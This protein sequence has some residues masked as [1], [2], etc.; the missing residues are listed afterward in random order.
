EELTSLHQAAQKELEAIRAE[1]ADAVK[2]G[3]NAGKRAAEEVASLRVELEKSA[4]VKLLAEGKAAEQDEISRKGEARLTE[5][6]KDLERLG[7]EKEAAEHRV[8]ELTAER[9]G[10]LTEKERLAAEMESLKARLETDEN[11]DSFA[12]DLVEAKAELAKLAVEK[13]AAERKEKK[14]A[15]ERDK[16][17]A[18]VERVT[19]RLGELQELQKRRDLE[20]EQAG[21]AQDASLEALRSELAQLASAR[22]EAEKRERELSALHQVT[23][24]ELAAAKAA[25][26]KGA[27]PAGGG[28][29]ASLAAL[30][31]ELVQLASAK[32]E[33]EKRELELS[34]RH[35]ITVAELA[36]VKAAL[37]KAIADKIAAERGAVDAGVALQREV[38]PE[39]RPEELS[40]AAAIGFALTAVRTPQAPWEVEG[41][42][43]AG[44]ESFS[45]A[46][47]EHPFGLGEGEDSGH[48]SSFFDDGLP[49]V[50]FTVD[51]ALSAVEY[52]APED[53]VALQLSINVARITPDGEL[54]QGSNAYVC[55][56]RKENAIHVFVAMYLIESRRTI[57]YVP[58][59]QPEDEGAYTKA[60]R[61]ALGFAEAVGFMMDT[62]ALGDDLS[63]R[64]EIL[65][66][67]PVL[68]QVAAS[69]TH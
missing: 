50:L 69:K 10:L 23:V 48:F 41:M 49:P 36:A 11:E 42:P 60:A 17:V 12:H 61:D 52:G 38:L 58:E 65:G 40:A 6:E 35:Q 53:V 47:P 26:E 28:Q 1:L 5:L 59:I 55:S 67:I 20:A 22:A 57:V 8:E 34:V 14:L 39:S 45:G 32:A 7:G 51:K 43:A 37:E 16:L 25:L 63:K 62:V 29:E 31:S 15:A 3:E 54:P 30:R 13:K 44:D 33:A 64:A 56:I 68:R 9:D 27:E 18:E 24:A 4:A 2:K 66:K 46:I 21:G 19:S